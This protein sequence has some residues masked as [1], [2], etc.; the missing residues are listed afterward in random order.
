MKR[1]QKEASYLETKRGIN[2]L[3]VL[4]IIAAIIVVI[5]IIDYATHYNEREKSRHRTVEDVLEVVNKPTNT[6]TESTSGE[7]V[8][9]TTVETSE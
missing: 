6:T 7:E 8:V 1:R 3:K 9:T 4:G 5:G 2:P